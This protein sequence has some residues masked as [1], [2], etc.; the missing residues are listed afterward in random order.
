MIFFVIFQFP[1]LSEVLHF[2]PISHVYLSGQHVGRHRG[3]SW[4]HVSQ[5]GNR[6]FNIGRSILLRSCRETETSLTSEISPKPARAA[7][8]STSHFFNFRET[9]FLLPRAVGGYQSILVTSHSLPVALPV[10]NSRFSKPTAISNFPT[11]PIPKSNSPP[12]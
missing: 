11:I 7:R 8:A 6:I 3:I 10:S 5:L 9:I 2:L 1:Y 12:R 4:K